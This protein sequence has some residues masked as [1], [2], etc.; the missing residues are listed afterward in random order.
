MIE[1]MV[2]L[3]EGI[4]AG[5]DRG[6][7]LLAGAER[8]FAS[9]QTAILGLLLAGGA[10]E[11]GLVSGWLSR[12]SLFTHPGFFASSGD[13]LIRSLGDGKTGVDRFVGIVLSVAIPY[14]AALWLS[15]RTRGR[16][17][18]V[19][20]FAGSLLFGVT[21]LAIYPAGAVD[22]FHNI[23]DGRLVWV[24]HLNAMLTAP[25][26][27]STDPLYPY[28]HYWQNVPS[29]YGP[30]WFL[31]TAPAVLLGGA[32]RESS[33]IAFKALPFV[34]ELIALGLIAR[35][36][37]RLRPQRVAAAVVLF[38]WNPLVL[39]E[40]AGNGHNDIV[41]M[42]FVLLALL[43]LISRRWPLAFP[44]LACSILVKYV[45]LILVPVFVIW[46]LRRD[47]KSALVPLS[48]GL[49]AALFVAVIL[50]APFW[51]GAGTFAS[52]HDQQNYF[53]FSPASAVLGTWGE[54][55]ANTASVLRVKSEFTL[56]FVLLYAFTLLRIK[57]TYA[58]LVRAS[59]ETIF[60]LLVLM[61]WWFWPWYV[62]W[63]LALA[64]LLPGSAH[65]RLAV[66]FSC[67]VLLIYV[68]SSWR[69][70]IWNFSS[71]FAMAFGTA[72]L[73]FLAPVLYAVM[74]LWRPANADGEA[75]EV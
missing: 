36:V 9:S 73:V 64:A 67:T 54:R 56:A 52:L 30:L 61:T 48:R 10:L 12:F 33:L 71:T 4:R 49:V 50:L 69:L 41:M 72:L 47:G 2:T 75:I 15:A 42:S 65:A 16:A 26:A 5:A 18:L 59:V 44:L 24:Y 74:H 37:Q 55:L 32:G 1:P 27:V 13:L 21:M 66:L 17:G 70:S 6:R 11:W 22:V 19:L 46:I 38:G 7:C 62:I 39:W 23:M 45:S 40:I 20:A 31:L 43:V 35:I 58:G 28:L 51:S 63:M 34:F 53:I 14:A 3:D 29:A 25:S 57:P 68:A 60:L 8:L